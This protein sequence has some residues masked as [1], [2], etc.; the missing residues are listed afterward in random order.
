MA[1]V[2]GRGVDFSVYPVLGQIV[3]PMR[4]PPLRGILVFVACFE[5][6]L[7]TV[8]VGAERLCMANRADLSVLRGREPVGLCPAGF[9]VHLWPFVRM[10]LT[11]DWISLNLNGVFLYRGVLCISQ[12]IQHP[13]KRDGQYRYSEC[14]S[15]H[16]LGFSSGR[17]KMI[18]DLQESL[19]LFVEPLILTI[20]NIR[21]DLEVL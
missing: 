5:L 16:L 1:A 18:N 15:F 11:A 7:D 8:A 9:V 20:L 19:R 21:P 6:F 4:E 13:Q 3:S 14:G 10:A 17:L 2:T 12:C